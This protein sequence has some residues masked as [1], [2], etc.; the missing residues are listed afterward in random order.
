MP[1]KPTIIKNLPS[2][3]GAFLLG[4]LPQFNASNKHQVLERW[5]EECGD[6][7]KIN[8]V[9]KEFVVSANADLNAEILK[10][11]PEKFRRFSK[12]N[13]ILT[14][15]GI[16][17]VFNA[18]G[19]T[20]KRHRKPTSEAL[21]L[22][23]IKG[24]Y[25]IISDKTKQ[26]LNKWNT[27]AENKQQI[28]IQKEFV[29]YTIDITTAVAFGY[30][31]D[32][33]NHKEDDFQKHLEYIFPMINER[34]TA[35]IPLWRIY[36]QKKDK[37]LDKSLKAIE[38][39]VYTF[40]HEAK[41][42]LVNTPGLKENPSN[43]LEALLVEQ[44]NENLF[45]TKEIYG[46]VFTIL[47]A[48][49]DTTSNSI[50]WALYYLAQ[51]P[52]IIT[53]VRDEAT[54]IYSDSQVPET[55]QALSKLKYANAV[56]QEA[57]RLKPVTPNLYM[58]AIEDITVHNL[59]IPKDTTIMLQNKVAQTMEQYFSNTNEFIPE[60]WLK[61]GCPMQQ[62]HNPDIIKAF[63]GGAR[64]CP[65]MNLA[66]HEMTIAISTI[67]KQ[68]DFSLTVNPA[69]VKEGFAFTMFPENL[70]IKIKKAQSNKPNLI[71]NR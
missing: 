57:I 15:M 30:K 10:L 61:S 55:T 36:K 17:G 18:E 63:G 1:T 23:K 31:L 65:G 70:I 19:D 11:R 9:G 47:L 16:I 29:R 60:R 45:S 27:Y 33:I 64:F 71:R 42:R 52:E 21:N 20:W 69:N 67:C 25:P 35:P 5:V 34:I 50:S 28:D 37:A 44:E 56:A 3:K 41:E 22:K 8:F 39:I 62:N 13:E 4:H 14:E 7:F 26:L 43:F 66:I 58:Q 40:I 54:E 51:H 12:I 59:S 49:E 68:F 2:P 48:G 24:Y 6:L 53:K 46:N 38:Q 32:T